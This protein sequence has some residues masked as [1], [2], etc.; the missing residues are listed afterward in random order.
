MLVVVVPKPNAGCVVAG[1]APNGLVLFVEPKILVEGCVVP[2]MEPVAGAVDVAVP[3]GLA[4]V[5]VGAPKRLVVD[6]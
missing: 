2:K 6:G 3:N 1:F 5:V 4:V